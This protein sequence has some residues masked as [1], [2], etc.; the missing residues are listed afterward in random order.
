[1]EHHSLRR[2][3]MKT[4]IVLS[5]L[6]TIAIAVPAPLW[7]NGI[8]QD[9]K[10]NGIFKPV[11]RERKST[12]ES[13]AELSLDND[14]G[15]LSNPA[16]DHK[17]HGFRKP[18]LVKK[19]FGYQIFRD[20][21]EE[22]AQAQPREKCR[23]QFRF[24]LCDESGE[25]TATDTKTINTEDIEETDVQHSLKMAKE[26]V[27]ILQKD[28]QKIEESSIVQKHRKNEDLESKLHKSIEQ[29]K[30]ASQQLNK[31]INNLDF[32]SSKASSKETNIERTGSKLEESRMI[33]WKEAIENIQKNVEI[34]KNIEETFKSS[35]L[36]HLS[37]EE[38]E[39][40]K[41][42]SVDHLDSKHFHALNSNLKGREME[43]LT[44]K[45]DENLIQD[46]LNKEAKVSDMVSYA[47]ESKQ[48]NIGLH[49]DSLKIDTARNWDITESMRQAENYGI[50]KENDIKEVNTNTP[51]E[52]VAEVKSSEV[53]VEEPKSVKHTDQEDFQLKKVTKKTDILEDS[54]KVSH[55]KI[56]H[57]KSAKTENSEKLLESSNNIDTIEDMKKHNT[58]D[59]TKLKST[60]DLSNHGKTIESF[61]AETDDTHIKNEFRDQEKDSETSESRNLIQTDNLISAKEA[62]NKNSFQEESILAVEKNIDSEKKSIIESNL[63]PS[64]QISVTRSADS[65]NEN[66]SGFHNTEW[67]DGNQ[68][69]MRESLQENIGEKQ[70]LEKTVTEKKESEINNIQ[71]DQYSA[72]MDQSRNSMIVES[73]DDKIGKSG[74]IETTK[75]HEH[76]DPKISADKQINHNT[77]VFQKS[78]HLKNTEEKSNHLAKDQI[79]LQK[80]KEN[81]LEQVSNMRFNEFGDLNRN[82][83]VN[84]LDISP[85]ENDNQQRMSEMDFYNNH[86]SQHDAQLVA[87]K[88]LDFHASSHVNRGMSEWER[89]QHHLHSMLRPTPFMPWMQ[90]RLR[91]NVELQTGNHFHPENMGHLHLDHHDHHF[92]LDGL[93]HH[94]HALPMGKFFKKTDMNHDSLKGPMLRDN[95]L[96]NGGSMDLDTSMQPSM[97][98]N[99]RGAL[100]RSGMNWDYHQASGKSGFG[101]NIGSGAVGVFPNANTGCGIPLLLSCSPSVVSGSL[102]KQ[103][104]LGYGHSLKSGDDLR[105]YTKRDAQGINDIETANSKTIPTSSS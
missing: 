82:F 79:S 19:K 81:N 72:K 50:Q 65:I 58:Q 97:K 11:K 103:S 45:K 24:K 4:I 37:G 88:N 43:S 74:I 57:E 69:K 10:L 53:L 32:L 27:K 89:N 73:N 87:D 75:I 41:T 39:S 64:A 54:E 98:I 36:S 38:T 15:S 26:A 28:L 12:Q 29:A 71:A 56:Q 34:V 86:N 20:S 104:S 55:N 6:A 77:A 18:I 91:N 1:M 3:T 5:A 31:N 16:K 62:L 90:D 83:P 23:R 52:N 92:N 22:L 105:F 70:V 93:H 76:V 59:K 95:H 44:E 35:E 17:T 49:S 66:A 84:N 68:L 63:H 42:K 40:P 51:Q 60:E 13:P 14:S 61:T 8:K 102:A 7:Q 9:P 100:D 25:T 48:T 67:D 78:V 33:L 47:T 101:S 21:D 94:H 2:H 30:E 99:M 80:N 85:L 46:N 96:E